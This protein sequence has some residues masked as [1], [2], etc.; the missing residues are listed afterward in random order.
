MEELAA[1]LKKIIVEL[2]I[3]KV[4]LL[5]LKHTVYEI[6]Q[7]IPCNQKMQIIDAYHGG[8]SWWR[9]WFNVSLSNGRISVRNNIDRLFSPIRGYILADPDFFPKITSDLQEYVKRIYTQ[10]LTKA[11]IL[12]NAS[13]KI[14]A[15]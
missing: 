3:P 10:E 14:S 9:C 13:G 8:P 5:Q 6:G 1:I 12:A 15:F 11:L 2:D 7:K 4:Q